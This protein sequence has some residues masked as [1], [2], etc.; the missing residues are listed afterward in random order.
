MNLKSS[1]KKSENADQYLQNKM[2][3]GKNGI[4]I[5]EGTVK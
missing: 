2:K 1:D 5:K 4:L 3:P